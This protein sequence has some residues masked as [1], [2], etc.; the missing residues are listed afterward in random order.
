M[1]QTELYNRVQ[2]ALQNIRPFLNEDGGDLELLSVDNGIAKVEFK[3]ACSG[4]TMNNLT[5]KSGVEQAILK[6]VPEI[7][8]VE[9]VNLV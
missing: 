2:S 9:A 7:T 8:A 4:C 5:F 1:A 3:G 6:E